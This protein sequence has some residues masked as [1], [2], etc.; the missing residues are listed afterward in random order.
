MSPVE[1][2]WPVPWHGSSFRQYDLAS[3]Y[4][5]GMFSTLQGDQ[6]GHFEASRP[7][8]LL[9]QSEIKIFGEAKT[10]L[11]ASVRQIKEASALNFCGSK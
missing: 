3:P 11:K 2:W 6:A 5:G 8:L 9:G 4:P 1:C 10:K 7:F